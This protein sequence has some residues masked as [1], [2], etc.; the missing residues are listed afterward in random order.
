MRNK[1]YNGKLIELHIPS[2]RGINMYSLVVTCRQLVPKML[3]PRRYRWQSWLTCTAWIGMDKPHVDGCVRADLAALELRDWLGTFMGFKS[4]Y[5]LS[6]FLSF[7][8]M[9]FKNKDVLFHDDMLL[10]I[11]AAQR[12]GFY[13]AHTDQ[14]GTACICAL[15]AGHGY[16]EVPSFKKALLYTEPL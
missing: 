15:R 4:L 3:E 2:D 12:N 13:I 11:L 7:F 6:R 16:A 9:D 5:R 1:G 8:L 14:L 10:Y